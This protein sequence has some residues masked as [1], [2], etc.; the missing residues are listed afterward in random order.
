MTKH[1]F[2]DMSLKKKLNVPS[3]GVLP[4]QDWK[5]L[6]KCN[7]IWRLCSLCSLVLMAQCIMNSY[8]E[9]KQS[10][11]STTYKFNA[12]FA[13]SNMKKIPGLW[14]NNSWLS[15]HDT[16]T[17]RIP[18]L[19]RKFLAKNNIVKMPQKVVQCGRNNKKNPDSMV[20]CKF[21]L[22]PKIKRT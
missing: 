17:T 10:I 19:V 5:R 4:R 9:V 2:T 16:A 6:N 15:H 21:F 13:W 18:V 12:P 8:H 14:K 11:R 3:G 22:F 20:P 1:G 7:R